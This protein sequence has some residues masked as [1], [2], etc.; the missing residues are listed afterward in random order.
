MP[1]KNALDTPMVMKANQNAIP[2]QLQPGSLMAVSIIVHHGGGVKCATDA[3]M[4]KICM[5]DDFV[6]RMWNVRTLYTPG[7]VQE[8]T[9]EMK[10][11]Y[12]N[13]IGLGEI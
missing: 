10:R 7:K 2:D 11:Y 12:L 4:S 9:H 13:I 1:S 3:L 6:I 8:L 5:R